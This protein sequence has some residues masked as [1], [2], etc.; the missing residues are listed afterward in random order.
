MKKLK[1]ESIILLCHVIKILRCPWVD[2]LKDPPVSNDPFGRELPQRSIAAVRLTGER[3]NEPSYPVFY[4]YQFTQS[5]RSAV[6][7]WCSR[8]SLGCNALE[9]LRNTQYSS[10]LV[11]CSIFFA[12]HSVTII[13]TCGF[14][15][16]ASIGVLMSFLFLRVH[17]KKLHSIVVQDIPLLLVC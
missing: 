9:L 2:S 6:L 12:G 16:T 15:V 11:P 17:L 8:V 3:H 7:D 13:S 5:T 10:F 14:F 4:C 1:T